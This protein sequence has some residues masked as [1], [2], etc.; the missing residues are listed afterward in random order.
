MGLVKAKW[1]LSEG[2][3]IT[4][5]HSLSAE[6]RET[7]AQEVMRVPSRAVRSKDCWE[8]SKWFITQDIK[9]YSSAYVLRHP[10]VLL[11]KQI[12]IINCAR[13]NML[14]IHSTKCKVC[15]PGFQSG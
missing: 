15:G 13:L 5:C 4:T 10:I 12:A 7:V 14:G 9:W 6:I 3:T 11:Q 8:E 2:T 1:N